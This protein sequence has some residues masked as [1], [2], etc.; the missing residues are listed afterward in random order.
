MVI[1]IWSD[2]ETVVYASHELQ[3]YLN[4]MDYKVCTDIISDVKIEKEITEG[5]IKLGLLEDF[6][7]N[8]DQSKKWFGLY[9]RQQL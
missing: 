7:L 8:C 4:A 9:C 5:E 2:N 6:G 1:K 3:K